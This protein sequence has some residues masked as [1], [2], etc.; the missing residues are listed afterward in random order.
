M[1]NNKTK[2]DNNIVTFFKGILLG[3]IS[4]GIPGLSASTIGIIVGIYFFMVEAIANIFK[5]FRKNIFFLL[6]LIL[7]YA[8]GAVGAS[9]FITFLL[10]L[11]PYVVTFAI[12]GIIL[13]AII[14]SAISLQGHFNKLSNWLTF[15]G[16]FLFLGAYNLFLSSDAQ[17]TFPTDPTLFD[18]IVM[19]FVG[20]FTSAT[21]IIPGIDFAVV[22]MSLGIYTPFMNMIKDLFAFTSPDYLT[23]LFANLK[24]LGFYL[25]GYFI[26]IFLFSKLIKFLMKRFEYQLQFAA[27]AF[28]VA[29]PPVF[30]N[31]CIIANEATRGMHPAQIIIGAVLSLLFAVFMLWFDYRQRKRS[32]APVIPPA[33]RSE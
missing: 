25:A 33:M 24:I 5:E 15:L 26:G 16:V 30:L 22:F 29:A 19:F 10:D 20:L 18:L 32:A 12:L 6:S 1:L 21:F 3:L 9:F 7:G 8:V 27:F 17:M 2:R 4:L 28:I 13:G 23:V 11:F 31:S 14:N